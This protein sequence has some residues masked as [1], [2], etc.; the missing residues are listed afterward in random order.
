[1]SDQKPTTLEEALERIDELEFMQA[2]L[3]NA[4]QHT[5]KLP[6]QDYKR[7]RMLNSE[8]QE[9]WASIHGQHEHPPEWELAQIA[10]ITINWLRAVGRVPPARRDIGAELVSCRKTLTTIRA[11]WAKLYHALI[12]V[13][14]GDFTRRLV[15]FNK[16][17]NPDPEAEEDQTRSV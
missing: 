12:D 9:L 6:A 1:M 3:E 7:Y 15:E 8:L 11:R 10:G 16:L 13:M 5:D 4:D 2:A 17:L 14:P